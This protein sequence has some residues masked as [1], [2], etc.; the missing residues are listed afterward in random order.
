[1]IGVRGEALGKLRR[2]AQ[3]ASGNLRQHEPVMPL[4]A[5]LLQDCK[6]SGESLGRNGGLRRGF[7]KVASQLGALAQLVQ[8]GGVVGNRWCR[9]L[10]LVGI[11]IA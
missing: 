2:W 5:G 9:G 10:G 1:M 3:L 7:G 6:L 8:L 4:A 11:P